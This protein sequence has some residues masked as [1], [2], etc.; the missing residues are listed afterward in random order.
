MWAWLQLMAL[1]GLLSHPVSVEPGRP[2]PPD[3]LLTTGLDAERYGVELTELTVEDLRRDLAHIRA[4][5]RRAEDLLVADPEVYSHLFGRQI[6]LISA[7]DDAAGTRARPEEAAREVCEVLRSDVGYVGEGMDLKEG[8][9]EVMD[10]RGFHGAVGGF[11]I[12]IYQG[13]EGAVPSVRASCQLTFPLSEARA[14][15]WRRVAAKD[16]ERTNLVVVTTGLVDDKGYVCP[17]DGWLADALFTHGAGEPSTMPEHV[18][19]VLLHC[20][21]S[22]RLAAVYERPGAVLPY[23]RS[24]VR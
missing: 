16:V 21:R 24:L 22:G 14:L 3:R 2:D 9:P 17:A 7:S 13:Q 5:S 15:L 18:D 4:I 12:Q 6:H 23:V 20:L 1:H 19:G 10:R 11:Q 8:L